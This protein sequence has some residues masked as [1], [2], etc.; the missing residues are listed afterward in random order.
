MLLNYQ[1]K[2]ATVIYI[3]SPKKNPLLKE[4]LSY[5]FC[6]QSTGYDTY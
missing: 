2:Y 4:I 5:L 1:F 3:E 6:S